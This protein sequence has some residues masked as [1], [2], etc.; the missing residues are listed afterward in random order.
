MNDQNLDPVEVPLASRAMRAATWRF[1]TMTISTAVQF[2]VGIVLARLLPPSDFGLIALAFLLAGLATLVANLGLPNA[3]VQRDILTEKH[4]RVAFTVSILLGCLVTAVVW[5]AAPL[6]TFIFDEPELPGILRVY[7]LTFVISGFSNTSGALARRQLDFRTLFFVGIIGYVFGYAAIAIPMAVMGFGVWS[8]VAGRMGLVFVQAILLLF[9]VRHSFKPLL[10][11]TELRHLLG[12]GTGNALNEFLQYLARSGD[13]FVV[14][15]WVGGATPLGLYNRAFQQMRL[16][17]DSLGQLLVSVL[18]PTFA[19][20][21]SD[22]KLFGIAFLWSI[23]LATLLSAP[24]MAGMFVAAPHLMVG[25]YG[26]NWLGSVQ[27]F[28]FLALGGVLAT[29]YPLATVAAEALG[30]V[31]AVSLRSGIFAAAVVILGIIAIPWGIT[32]VSAAVVVSYAIVYF[33]TS[34]LAVR[35]AGISRRGFLRAHVPGLA[36]A[37]VVGTVAMVTR[38]GLEH[39][40]LPHLVILA[41]L[42]GACAVS[43]WASIRWLPR[44]MRPDQLIAQIRASAPKV[45]A[46]LDRLLELLLGDL[47]PPAQEFSADE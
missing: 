36:V 42:I 23:E 19:R 44:S 37:G 3:V 8:F 40:R 2:A 4:V 28:Q 29:L 39:F 31:Y 15:R 24:L 6:S 45:P 30:R 14:G 41:V 38:L 13:T 16:A 7:S 9:W 46:R 12:F 34:S 20:L 25:L 17:S 32:G 33:M 5:L 35:A 21:Q 47:E 26:P 11:P 22:P 1:A 27:P 10:A 18:F 43:M